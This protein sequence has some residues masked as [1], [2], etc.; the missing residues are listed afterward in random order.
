MRWIEQPVSDLLQC[1][2]C[3]QVW[4]GTLRLFWESLMFK[5]S[6]FAPMPSDDTSLSCMTVIPDA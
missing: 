1:F 5:D 4:Q 6:Q 3:R 2:G